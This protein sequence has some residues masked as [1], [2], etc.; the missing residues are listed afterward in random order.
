[1]S[2]P[3]WMNGLSMANFRVHQPD[4]QPHVSLEDYLLQLRL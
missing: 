2:R 1:M 3:D 4:A